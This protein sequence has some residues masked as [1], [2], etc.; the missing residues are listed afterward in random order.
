MV[1]LATIYN[2][3]LRE[4]ACDVSTHTRV[5]SPHSGYEDPALIISRAAFR[6]LFKTG[7]RQQRFQLCD[8]PKLLARWGNLVQCHAPSLAQGQSGTARAAFDF[9]ATWKA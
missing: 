4:V 2:P 7:K 9:D 3:R 5:I 8:I 6:H 1:D